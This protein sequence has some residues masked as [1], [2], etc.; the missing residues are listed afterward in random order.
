MTFLFS[1]TPARCLAVLLA[2]I[3]CALLPSCATDEEPI[4]V[5]KSGEVMRPRLVGRVASVPSDKRFILIQSYGDWKVAAGTVLIAH[6]A[7]GRT[8]NLLATGEVMGQYAAADVQS[9]E[10]QRGDSVYSRELTKSVAPDAAPT[11]PGTPEIPPPAPATNE[12]PIP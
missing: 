9:G 3:F 6:G 7:D 8:A 10:V 5:T 12:V 4:P 2:P 1:S 11:S